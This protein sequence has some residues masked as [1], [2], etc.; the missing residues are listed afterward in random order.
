[1][2]KVS[3]SFL[4]NKLRF[5]FLLFFLFFFFLFVNLKLQLFDMLCPN[6]FLMS[7]TDIIIKNCCIFI[8]LIIKLQRLPYEFFFRKFRN[9]DLTFEILRKKKLKMKDKMTSCYIFEG[10]SVH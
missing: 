9:Y 4:V 1:M 7:R 2:V 5:F 10:L 3:G 6:K 8:Y